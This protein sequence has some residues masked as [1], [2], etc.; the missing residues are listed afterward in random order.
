MLSV[1]EAQKMILSE[2]VPIGRERVPLALSL[3]RILAEEI[4]SKIDDPPWD[5]SAMDGFAVCSEDT[6]SASDSN[7]AVLTVIEAVP[8]GAMPEKMVTKGTASKVMTGAP[9]PK[10]ADAVVKIEDVQASH[11]QTITLTHFVPA[12]DFIR[13]R[14]GV[15]HE[16]ELLLKPGIPIR[17]YEIALMAAIGVSS[18][19]VSKRP[20]VAVLSTGDE[21][22]DIHEDRKPHQI[23]NSNGYALAAQVSESGGVPLFLG[24]AKDNREDLTA[25]LKKASEAD[26]ILL[27]GGV[28]VGDY[29]IVKE[30]LVMK[31]WKVAMKPGKPLAFGRFSGKIAFGLPGNPVSAM[32]TF[33]QFVRPALLLSQG[34]RNLF[35]PVVQAKLMAK[36]EKEEG[37]C[38]FVRGRLVLADGE[39]QVTPTGDQDSSN[40]VSLVA[41]NALIVIATETGDVEAGATVWV[42]VLS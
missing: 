20:I 40:I 10:G 32:V 26:F 16:G 29:D 12:E 35:L 9:I 18:V 6:Q 23:Y 11:D 1:A 8:A 24:I 14:G 22:A 17:P 37:R 39:Y 2:I 5:R 33:N 36:I 13:P 28:S 4:I 41:A 38:H 25:K 42:Q 7:P 21:L 31:F 19:F 15:I 34:S 30:V 3:G 27:S